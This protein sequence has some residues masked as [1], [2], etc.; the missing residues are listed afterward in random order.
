[1]EKRSKIEKL[2]KQQQT[3]ARYEK[4]RKKLKEEKNYQA[5]SMLPRAASPV[6]LQNRCRI[7]GRP[8]GYLR[9][10]GVSRII[11]R[12]LAYRGEIPG[13]HKASW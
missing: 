2:K 13:V 7:T 5:L 12:E 10:Y 6:R 1:M 4:L 11:F 9:K 8:H 3:V